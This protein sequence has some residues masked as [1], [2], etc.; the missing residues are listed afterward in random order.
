MAI[1]GDGQRQRQLNWEMMEEMEEMEE[2]TDM[3]I[4]EDR[5]IRLNWGTIERETEKDN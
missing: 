1:G 3:A 2:M 5:K 4:E